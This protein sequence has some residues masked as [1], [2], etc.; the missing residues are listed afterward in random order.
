MVVTGWWL[1]DVKRLARERRQAKQMLGAGGF[2]AG[3]GCNLEIGEDL[4]SMSSACPIYLLVN[5]ST[6]VSSM[7]WFL[8]WKKSSVHHLPLFRYAKS[9][10][11]SSSIRYSI[12]L[13]LCFCQFLFRRIRLFCLPAGLACRASIRRVHVSIRWSNPRCFQCHGVGSKWSSPK[14]KSPELYGSSMFILAYS[15]G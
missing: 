5:Y 4:Q 8:R 12:K 11:S 2:H 10:M 15:S 13:I 7:Y 1:R 9:S 14:M 6:I 3:V